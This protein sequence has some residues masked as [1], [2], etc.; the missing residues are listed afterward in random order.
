V[1]AHRLSLTGHLHGPH[2]TGSI[3]NRD[4]RAWCESQSTASESLH[5]ESLQGSRNPPIDA[6]MVMLLADNW[7]IE[8]TLRRL[9]ALSEAAGAEFSPD[10]VVKCVDGNLSIEAPPDSVGTVLMRLPWDCL[11]PISPFHLAVAGDELVISSYETSLTSTCVATMEAMLELY[12]LTNKLAVHRRTSP[13]SLLAEHPELLPNLMTGRRILYHELVRSGNRDQLEIKSFLNTRAFDYKATPGAPGFPVLL[14][15]LDAMNHHS[16]GAPFA[17]DDSSGLGRVLT[18]GRSRPLPE[19][20]NECFAFYR[21]HDCFDCWM[22]DG[23]IDETADFVRSLAM[24]IDIAGIGTIKMDDIFELRSKHE[25]PPPVHDLHFYIPK[26]YAT[27]RDQIHTAAVLIPGR[28]APRALRRTLHFLI[29]GLNHGRP[30]SRDLVLQAEQQ[31]IAANTAY[32]QTL[33]GVLRTMTLR[34][35]RQRPILHEFIRMCEIQ[36]GRLQ[37]YAGHAAG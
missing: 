35:E 7:E 6:S 16:Q 2:A 29:T 26:L 20:G 15:V 27:G 9:V 5:G 37:A 4:R 3:L 8:R 12:N 22:G 24:V 28:Q 31:V 19:A 25:L 33:A 14:P 11:V 1:S 18:V 36:L 13:W 34:D 10:L 21:P 23:F 32:Y 30:P 17:F